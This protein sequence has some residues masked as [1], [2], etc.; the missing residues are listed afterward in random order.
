MVRLVVDTVPL[1]ET[2]P[3]LRVP[4]AAMFPE[5]VR[6]VSTPTLVIFGCA[7]LVTACA[8]GTLPTRLAAGKFVRFAPEPANK[9]AAIVFV[10][11]RL[12]KVPTLVILG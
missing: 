4:D 12:A 2:F 9:F 3:P 8:S 11:L 6:L 1:T 10:T 7:A 5:L